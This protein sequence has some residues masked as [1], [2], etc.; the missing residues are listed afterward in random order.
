MPDLVASTVIACAS[1]DPDQYSR[2]IVSLI[3]FSGADAEKDRQLLGCS[4]SLTLSIDVTTALG[5]GTAGQAFNVTVD[6]IETNFLSGKIQNYW[7]SYAQQLKLGQYANAVVSS[8]S[9]G[10]YSS[11]TKSSGSSG[12]SHRRG[13]SSGTIITLA[14]TVVLVVLGF[15][16]VLMAWGYMVRKVWA[17]R[18]RIRAVP[19]ADVEIVSAHFINE[20]GDLF[21]N[22]LPGQNLPTAKPI[23]YTRVMSAAPTTAIVLE[24][25]EVL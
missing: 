13:F 16:L 23:Q 3:T 2:Y 15:P 19:Q 12:S 1:T 4:I 17:L 7:K 25:D 24:P 5:F 22:V 10:R 9:F 8:V 6:R 20:E 11:T 18:N 21:T 14:C